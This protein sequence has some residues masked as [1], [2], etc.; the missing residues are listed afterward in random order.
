MGSTCSSGESRDANGVGGVGNVDRCWQG[1]GQQCWQQTCQLLALLPTK[2]AHMNQRSVDF[3][4][5]LAGV[6]TPLA[7][8]GANN[9]STGENPYIIY[10]NTHSHTQ[11][12]RGVGT[13]WDRERKMLNK[14][15][16]FRTYFRARARSANMPTT[17]RAAP[18]SA[19]ESAPMRSMP[20]LPPDTIFA[21][22]LAGNRDWPPRKQIGCW[23]R[24][25]CECD[26]PEPPFTQPAVVR[27]HG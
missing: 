4:G 26:A 1:F 23:L 6:D 21:V 5:M 11:R 17:T 12:N 20:P 9:L 15:V 27:S 25:V 13:E 22:G 16:T 24:V 3:V 2:M 8:G 10:T 14:V 19:P 7:G 18:E